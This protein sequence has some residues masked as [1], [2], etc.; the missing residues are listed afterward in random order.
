[1][2]DAI[3]PVSVKLNSGMIPEAPKVEPVAM[4]PERRTIDPASAAAAADRQGAHDSH[5]TARDVLP[6]PGLEVHLDGPTLRLYSEMR[7]P[8]TKRVMLRIPTGYQPKNEPPRDYT[9]TEI[10]T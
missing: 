2:V 3:D 1:M 9:P 7:D 8:D 10:E 6:H 4:T 5:A